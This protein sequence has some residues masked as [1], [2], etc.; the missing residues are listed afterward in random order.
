MCLLRIKSKTVYESERIEMKKEFEVY[1][2]GHSIQVVNTWFGGEKLYID[3][4][5]QDENLGL[6]LRA[7]LNGVLR[8]EDKSIKS[9]IKVT[10]GGFLTVGCKIFVDHVL[11]YPR[12]DVKM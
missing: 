2:Q 9:Q 8:N 5:L 4:E 10:L 11:I 7:S 6:A 3:G 1:Y 12:T